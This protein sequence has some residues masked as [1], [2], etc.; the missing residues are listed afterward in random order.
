MTIE[1]LRNYTYEE[2]ERFYRGGVV[3][4]ALW[5]RYVCEW[6]TSAFRFSDL[7]SGYCSYC[8]GTH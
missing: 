2:V 6:R 7:G 1:Q 5:E 8:G 4:Q 3:S